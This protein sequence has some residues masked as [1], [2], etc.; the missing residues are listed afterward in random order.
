MMDLDEIKDL[1]S[2]CPVCLEK[3]DSVPIYQCRNGHVVCT[4]YRVSPKNGDLSHLQ[5]PFVP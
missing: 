3:I 2:E 4:E 5:S 1:I